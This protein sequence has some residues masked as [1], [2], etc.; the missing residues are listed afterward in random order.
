MNALIRSEFYVPRMMAQELAGRGENPLTDRSLR[1][2]GVFGRLKPGV[3][4]E[5]ARVEVARIAAQLEQENPVTNRGQSMTVYTQL[6]VRLVEDPDV[7]TA[8]L[9]FLLMG[10]LVLG[11]ACVNVANLLLST[12]P[13]R[14]RETAV[15]LALGATRTR[16]LSQF[17]VESCVISTLA[18]AAGF[19]IAALVA[20]FVRS[21]EIS[22]WLPVNIEM[23]ADS[24]VAL[25]AFAVGLG[26]GILSGVIPA[27]QC[28]RGN[29][30]QLMRAADPHVA[31]S[32]MPFRQVLVAT[33]VALA[34]VVLVVSG[35]GLQGLTLLKKAD[36]GFRVDNV[37][38]MALDPTM[39]RGAAASQ[40][41]RF[42]EELLQRVRNLP[43]VEAA[44][45]IQ[46]VPLGFSDSTTDV[47][48]EG[49]RMPEGQHSI[50][51]SS[52]I[53][54]GGCFDTL[55]IPVLRGRAF[56]ARD[57]NDAPRT[58]IINQA[59]AEKYWPGR[60]PLGKRIEIRGP[61]AAA[62][63]I[64]GIVGTTK[65]QN[66]QERP[67][68]F[69]YLPLGQSDQTFMWLLV[70]T[71]SDPA[72]FIPVVRD[73]VRALDPTLPIFDART[74]A[75]FVRRQALW[76]DRLF[77]QIAT[78]VGMIGL[79]LGVLGLYGMLAYSVSRRTREIGIRMAVGATSSQVS[80]MIVLQGLKLSVVGIGAGILLAAALASAMPDMFV[81]ADPEDPLVYGTVVLVLVAVT[82]LS[83]YYPARRA[84][85]ID[86]NECLRCE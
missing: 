6:G 65:Y 17:I 10:A 51:I 34:T 63:E 38:T 25:F 59:M 19:G 74:M 1:N 64:V 71:K 12:A 62:V 73:A 29:L 56:D 70:A 85:R 60:S 52:A 80:R 50:G 26:S 39:G 72:S 37:L 43:G 83:C 40:A 69:I 7:F 3:N 67:L 24:R 86:P 16:L 46:H 23:Q 4:I 21:I 35:L 57:R 36:P 48:I 28:S 9:L 27:F 44:G 77:A 61:K 18:T 30:N 42:Y 81:P 78:G 11:I 14:A 32:R 58:V 45:T 75:D 47:A 33:Q 55:G 82:L 2:A 49:Y 5:Q 8:S 79:L 20:R 41:P 84:A 31:R 68:P 22:S 13:A 54:S 53:I 76:G 66:F 15:R